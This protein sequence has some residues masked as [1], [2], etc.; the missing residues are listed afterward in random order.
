VTCRGRVTRKSAAFGKQFKSNVPAIGGHASSIASATAVRPVAHKPGPRSR[1]FSTRTDGTDG[2][3]REGPLLPHRQGQHVRALPHEQGD[4]APGGTHRGVLARRRS[5]ILHFHNPTLLEC[6]RGV[7]APASNFA[8]ERGLGDV[9]NVTS[10]MPQSPCPEPEPRYTARSRTDMAGPSHTRHT[11]GGSTDD[12]V[13]DPSSAVF[14]S[15]HKIKP[16]GGIRF[17]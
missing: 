14:S 1:P 9:H 6:R 3:L 5:A 11:D 4:G 8:G 12:S 13:Q 2:P 10:N 7:W 15:G 16:K 17:T